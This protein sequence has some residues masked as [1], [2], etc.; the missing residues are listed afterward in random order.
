MTQR[1]YSHF[2]PHYV[3]VMSDIT[4]SY[5]SRKC[6]IWDYTCHGT[7]ADTYLNVNKWSAQKGVKDK[8]KKYAPMS[9]DMITIC[10]KTT[11]VWGPSSYKFIE[12]I[13]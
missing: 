1:I 13:D 2:R 5:F 12:F 3:E 6:M 9:R 10:I 7:Y 8:V 4:P 11:R